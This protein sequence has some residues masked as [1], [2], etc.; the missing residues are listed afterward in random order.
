MALPQEAPRAHAHSTV[1]QTAESLPSPTER[2]PYPA[3]RFYPN[4]LID[5]EPHNGKSLDNSHIN[6][7]EYEE[8]GMKLVDTMLPD[9]HF[10]IGAHLLDAATIRTDLERG[11]N[12]R[13][14]MMEFDFYGNLTRMF[15]FKRILIG[16]YYKKLLQKKIVGISS[17]L[18]RLRANPL[19]LGQLITQ[20]TG[21]EI[22][23]GPITIP[24]DHELDP[25]VFIS[26]IEHGDEII[27]AE[28]TDLRGLFK[29][30]PLPSKSS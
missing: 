23:P 20:A 14:D 15:E 13:P 3:L 7:L 29:T 27:S 10:A 9:G 1:L 2:P 18:A 12:G 11:G 30:V 24:L 28:G 26:A 22:L 5:L 17:L 6:G 25:V 21:Q 8:H 16:P 4:G 19:R